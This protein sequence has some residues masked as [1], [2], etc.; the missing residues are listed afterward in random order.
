MTISTIARH[1]R[2]IFR[3]RS[4][5]I[6]Y[7]TLFNSGRF[8]SLTR[9]TLRLFAIT[10]CNFLENCTAIA[11]S[12]QFPISKEI[13]QRSQIFTEISGRDYQSLCDL[14]E[15]ALRFKKIAQRYW[16]FCWKAVFCAGNVTLRRV[17]PIEMNELRGL[18]A[19]TRAR[20][21]PVR[22]TILRTS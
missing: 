19:R 2:A 1:C 10:L 7:K 11:I 13:A 4:K 17:F 22:T 5:N 21:A 8:F 20:S 16:A 14:L 12:G 3:N 18:F 9:I 6:F 15:I